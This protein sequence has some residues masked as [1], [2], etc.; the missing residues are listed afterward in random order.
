MVQQNATASDQKTQYDHFSGA[1]LDQ[2][3]FS[4]PAEKARGTLSDHHKSIADLKLEA[5]AQE[6]SSEKEVYCPLLPSKQLDDQVSLHSWHP[7]SNLA[8]QL[9]VRLTA[10]HQR[11]RHEG[12]VRAARPSNRDDNH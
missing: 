4:E 5:Q 11:A 10:Q 7:K 1:I 8:D 3:I 12:Q 9:E 2:S 6:A